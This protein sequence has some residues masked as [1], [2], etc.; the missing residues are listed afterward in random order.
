[1]VLPLVASADDDE[2]RTAAARRYVRRVL[3]GA[4]AIAV[5]MIVAT[6]WLIRLLFGADFLGAATVTRVLLVA[7]VF[8]STNRVIAAL[9]NAVGRPLR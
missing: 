7:T 9:L 4:A 1:M 8:F 3:L 2:A 5:P 6:P